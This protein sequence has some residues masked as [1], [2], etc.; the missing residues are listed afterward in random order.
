MQFGS[1][2]G[3]RACL[4]LGLPAERPGGGAT[5]GVPPAVSPEGM[6]AC[7]LATGALEPERG[8]AFFT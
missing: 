7:R 8:M 2:L 6:P 5:T 3:V 4:P 1:S